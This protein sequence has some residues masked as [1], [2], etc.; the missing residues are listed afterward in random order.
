MKKNLIRLKEECRDWKEVVYS[1]I[2]PLE[3]DG[4]VEEIYKDN[5]I[6][7]FN[8]LGPYMV[9]AP[10]I[11]LLH[12]RPEDGVI[13]TG[14]SILT[15]K[16][17]INFGSDLNDPVRLVFSLCSKNNKDHLE[18]LS[19]LMKLLVSKEDL[20]NLMNENNIENAK[21]IIDKFNL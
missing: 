7:I 8:E 21:K 6:K 16:N 3:E 4:F 11:V 13:K 15:L 2:E 12:A 17:P 5:I 9:I 10:Q 20:E 14:L 19:N 18:L 1:S